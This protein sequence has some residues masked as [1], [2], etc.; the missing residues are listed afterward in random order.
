MCRA[1]LKQLDRRFQYHT[2]LLPLSL[3]LSAAFALAERCMDI[4]SAGFCDALDGFQP[5]CVQQPG[6]AS[7]DTFE[8]CKIY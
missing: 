1:H 7:S 3:L 5:S 6:G 2:S 8:V 4:I